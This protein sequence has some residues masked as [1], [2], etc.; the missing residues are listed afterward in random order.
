MKTLPPNVI[1]F[2]PFDGLPPLH[3]VDRTMMRRLRE[4]ADRRA[5]SVEELIH[6]ALGRWVAHCE[7]ERE[8]ETK[9]IRFPK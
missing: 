9:T 4:L 8:L 1:L 2:A 7:M 6:E 5:W 3:K